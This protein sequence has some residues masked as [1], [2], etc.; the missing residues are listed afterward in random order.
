MKL[1]SYQ[2]AMKNIHCSLEFKQ[3]M[4]QLID[5]APEIHE[6]ITT[7]YYVDKDMQNTYRIRK[8][9][10][11]AIS[12]ILCFLVIGTIIL[13]INKQFNHIP[14]YYTTPTPTNGET[15]TNTMVP[16]IVYSFSDMRIIPR[17]TITNEF[18]ISDYYIT[19]K[20]VGNYLHIEDSNLYLE[21]RSQQSNSTLDSN[22]EVIETII[23]GETRQVEIAQDVIHFDSSYPTVIY[24]TK[25]HQLFGYGSNDAGLLLED[26][27]SVQ[28]ITTPKLLMDHIA[29]AR[30]SY[31][32]VVAL[33]M[34]GD[35]Y[36]WGYIDD[37]QEPVITP[38]YMLSDAIFI[39]AGY[40]TGAAITSDGDL[41]CWG[42]NTFGNCGKKTTEEFVSTPIK[43]AEDVAMV[44]CNTLN[45]NTT[46]RAYAQ[47]SQS[48]YEVPNTLIQKKDGSLFICGR[49]IGDEIYS[50]ESNKETCT[51]NYSSVFLPVE[52]M[53]K[54]PVTLEFYLSLK[55]GMT[56]EMIESMANGSEIIIRKTQSNSP[57]CEYTDYVQLYNGLKKEDIGMLYYDENK[58]LIGFGI[59]GVSLD[60]KVQICSTF[61]DLVAA[62]GDNFTTKKSKSMQPILCWETKAYR[63][64]FIVSQNELGLM[65]YYFY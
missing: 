54:E 38:K 42:N 11:L 50:Y 20:G 49:D 25:N 2:K 9:V 36:T 34:D 63:I 41:W 64:E 58:C 21:Q 26:P 8:K 56:E 16:L 55:K 45:F 17:E 1:I 19:K 52:L 35:V 44:W 47:E 5:E 33:T 37:S 28:E 3:R 48:L 60:G 62:Y 6:N 43:T 65:N 53:E 30:I 14:S 39:A 24:I 4:L 12:S 22:G 10:I 7:S 29:Y 46:N 51:F 40:M 31:N 15:F 18:N 59:G 57:Y 27:K 61:D 13:T 32:K 23:N